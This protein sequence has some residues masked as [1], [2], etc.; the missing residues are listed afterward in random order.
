MTSEEEANMG[1]V[2]LKLEGPPR[3]IS[4]LALGEG[5]VSCTGF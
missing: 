4:A 2:H 5:L 1:D 3:L